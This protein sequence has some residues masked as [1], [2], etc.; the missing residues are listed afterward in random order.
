L[1]STT[2]KQKTKIQTSTQA[3][4]ENFQTFFLIM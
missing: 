1:F 3:K 2:K 4:R